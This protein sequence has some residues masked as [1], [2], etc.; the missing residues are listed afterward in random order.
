MENVEDD[1][2]LMRKLSVSLLSF[3]LFFVMATQVC[4]GQNQ[5]KIGVIG[6]I[7]YTQGKGFWNG[8]VLAAE[9]INGNGGVQFGNNRI[10][11][12]LI[13]A[14]SNGYL[15]AAIAASAA[16]MLI[17][18]YNVDFIVGG[19][20]SEVVLAIQDVAADHKKLFFSAGAASME[21]SRRVAQYYDRYKYYFRLGTLNNQDMGKACFLQLNYIAENLRSELGIKNIKVAIAAEKNKWVEEMIAAAKFYFPRMGLELAGV[22]QLSSVATNVSDTIKAIAR[23]RA[24]IVLTLFSGNAGIPFVS[25]AA[26]FNLP[27]VLVGINTEAQRND[28]WQ[29]TNGKADYAI[30]LTSFAPDVELSDRTKPFIDSYMEKFGDV[31]SYTAGGTYT[32]IAD[33]LA[34]TIEKAGTLDPDILVAAIEQNTYKTPQGLFVFVKD[35]L[36]RP[37]HDLKF[38]EGYALPLAIQW[39]DGQMKGIWPNNYQEKPG[40][41]TLTYKGIVD[42][43]IP[44]WVIEKHKRS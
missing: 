38:G 23:T 41:P 27:A 15:S 11:I 35:E 26:D 10:P 16:E 25:Q 21:L 28:F 1:I 14:D 3:L 22:F 32:A 6:P 5:I 17:F 20:R 40:A 9:E 19:F 39:Q 24:P 44:H 36:G 4:H 2:M 30:T 18:K 37:L 31:P 29:T 13:M 33:I 43:K 34:P 12:K 8:A 7:N 42:F